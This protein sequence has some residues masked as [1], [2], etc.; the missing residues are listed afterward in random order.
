M[1]RTLFCIFFSVLILS[2][3]SSKKVVSSNKSIT[4]AD[5]IVANA[6][7]Y[8]GVK[9]KFGGTTRRGMDCSGVIYVAFGQENFSLPRVSRDMAKKGTKISLKKAQKGD[10][11]FF[12]TDKNSRRINHVGLIVST[13]KGQIRFIHSTTSRGVIIS[14]LSEKYWYKSYVKAT[15]VL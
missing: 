5:K 14:S 7:R 4:K 15:K 10:L 8:K 11:L 6:L 2:C 9:Y 12:K 13:K 3:S 1:K